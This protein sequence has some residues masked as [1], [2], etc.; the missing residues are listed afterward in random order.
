[1]EG[2]YASFEL[3]GHQLVPNHTIA[4]EDEILLVLNHYG[5]EKP[6]LPRIFRDDPA[7]RVLDAKPGHVIRIERE[8]QTAGKVFYYRL[9][10][11]SKR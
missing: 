2:G 3:F 9:V 5:I 1:M 4:T 11:D 10:V 6:Q 8:S 7:A